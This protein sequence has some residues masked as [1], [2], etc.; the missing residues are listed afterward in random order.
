MF[1]VLTPPTKSIATA[2]DSSPF[3]ADLLGT[4]AS[5]ADCVRGKRKEKGFGSDDHVVKKERN[6]NT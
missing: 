1:L 4:L 5:F 6:Q 3:F 2:A